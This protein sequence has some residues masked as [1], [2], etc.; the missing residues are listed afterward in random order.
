MKRVFPTFSRL[1]W[2]KG[3]PV[4][5]SGSVIPARDE[6]IPSGTK[7]VSGSALG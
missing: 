3:F 4:W 7:L 6:D 5:T 1:L 2:I